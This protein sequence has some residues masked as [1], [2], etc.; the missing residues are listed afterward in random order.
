M[1][2]YYIFAL[3]L[4]GRERLDPLFELL[5]Q[6]G[7]AEFVSFIQLLIIGIGATWFFIQTGL[8]RGRALSASAVFLLSVLIVL[9]PSMVN[10]RWHW[11]PAAAALQ[12]LAFR[13]PRLLHQFLF[14]AVMALFI[15]T[16][17]TLAPIG[18]LFL[19]LM[20]CLHPKDPSPT[21]QTQRYPF[22]ALAV[23]LG[24]V[25]SILLLP[26]YPMPEYPGEARLAPI[27][28]LL[29]SGTPM[30]GPYLQPFPIVESVYRDLLCSHFVLTSVVLIVLFLGL[31]FDSQQ[32][33]RSLA[34]KFLFLGT[35]LLFVLFAELLPVTDWQKALPFPALTRLLPGL[36]LAPL[37]WLLLPF[38]LLF[39]VA[40][41][42]RT[43][44][45]RQA[46]SASVLGIVL[47]G[48]FYCQS[49]SQRLWP[50]IATA[51][52]TQGTSS[53]STWGASYFLLEQRGDWAK[54]S[55][56][57]ES[58]TR[59]KRGED[60]LVSVQAEPNMSDAALAIDGDSSTRWRT[61]RPQRKGDFFALAFEESVPLVRVVLSVQGVPSD[62]PRAI[63]IVATLADGTEKVVFHE[64][65]WF[66]PVKW[67]TEGLPYFGPQSEVV[68][69]FPEELRVKA[70]RFELL[71]D[72]VVFDWAI[73]EIKLFRF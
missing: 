53:L 56:S 26:S 20:Y 2:D 35:I 21:P 72:E 45:L 64:E 4:P 68:F 54:T 19:F 69:D 40:V 63:S 49:S 9:G 29:L 36:A 59:L 25:V 34:T 47:G 17:G 16:A 15:F 60:F 50:Q 44:F 31:R 71:K 8:T 7:A 37:P 11:F 38:L 28:S 41:W 3:N 6:L 55:R 10:L 62:Y 57:F 46:V 1:Y 18:G 51:E 32:A 48:L 33:L 22:Q 70:L 39:A 42:G 61:A 73:T 14:V 65:D 27:S 12:L 5:Q 13:S 24:I 67:T 58:L 43:D 52:V 66:G 30:L 23:L